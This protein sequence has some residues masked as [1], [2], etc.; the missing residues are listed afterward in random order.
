MWGEGSFF[1]YPEA[2]FFVHELDN[3]GDGEP[4]IQLGTDEPFLLHRSLGHVALALS[5]RQLS[6]APAGALEVHGHLTNLVLYRVCCCGRCR[7][8]GRRLARYRLDGD[9]L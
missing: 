7:L 1:L 6:T 8:D 9:W 5:Q 4:F 3:L 2:V